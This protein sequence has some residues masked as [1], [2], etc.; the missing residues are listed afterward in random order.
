ML[1]GKTS[2]D[3][4][5]S[6]NLGSPPPTP[7]PSVPSFRAKKV[8]EVNAGRRRSL[9]ALTT[10]RI[11]GRERF[12]LSTRCFVYLPVC[13][14]AHPSK[15]RCPMSLLFIPF[16]ILPGQVTAPRKENSYF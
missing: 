2:G 14:A 12:T 8:K 16:P 7:P 1:Q 11:Y 3:L 5:P 4:G 13:P 9:P 10:R 6:P 15:G